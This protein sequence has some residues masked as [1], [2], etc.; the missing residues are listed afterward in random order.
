M[1]IDFV[2]LFSLLDDAWKISDFGLSSEATYKQLRTTQYSH[3]KACYRAPELLDLENAKFSNK[4]DIWALGCIVSEMITGEKRFSSDYAMWKELHDGKRGKNPSQENPV[5]LFFLT[6]DLLDV[7]P[8]KRP[9]AERFRKLLLCMKF[10]SSIETSSENQGLD[11]RLIAFHLASVNGRKDIMD[12]VINELTKYPEWWVDQ[13]RHEVWMINVQFELGLAID[14][15]HISQH[16]ALDHAV[17]WGYEK[18][19][20]HLLN[21]DR[22]TSF[23]WA[24]ATGHL[25][26]VK[27]LVKEAG[28]NVELKDKDGQTPLSLAATNGHLEIVKF[29]IQEGGADVESKDKI[30]EWT[31]LSW[32][33]ENGHLEVVK[34]LVSA[35]VQSKDSEWGGTPLSYAAGNGHLEVVKF[36]VKEAG[37]DVESKDQLSGRTPLSGAAMNGRL[38]IVKFL[39]EEGGADV[40]S[41]DIASFLSTGGRTPLIHAAENGLLEVVKFLVE[42]GGAD[43]ESIDDNGNTALDL[44]RQG[45]RDSWRQEGCSAVA[46]WLEKKKRGGGAWKRRV[47]GIADHGLLEC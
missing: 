44:A 27:F 20:Q 33:A 6:N 38:E 31:P 14:G 42:E 4:S 26:V 25:E 47:G 30:L 34:F 23:L 12:E 21:I 40:E 19:L 18:T 35:N 10:V 37:T 45:A 28:T 8:S 32:A 11:V 2:V 3:G 43:V 5:V 39:V 29:L 13:F 46:A 15:K 24:G 7:V 41:K 9:S 1:L 22:R 16:W 17:A 36:L